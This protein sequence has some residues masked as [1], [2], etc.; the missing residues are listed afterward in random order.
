MKI[1]IKFLAVL[2]TVISATSATLAFSGGK[3]F[4]QGNFREADEAASAAEKA[5]I[6]K[7]LSDNDYEGWLKIVN[8]KQ[9]FEA[10]V[11]RHKARLAKMA[12]RLGVSEEELQTALEDGKTIRAIAQE[13]GREFKRPKSF[14]RQ[15][16]NCRGYRSN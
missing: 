14:K 13:K 5:A 1:S 6:R 9:H 11:A 2:I 7:A 10:L 16:A 8:S 15:G 4:W 3:H 12:E